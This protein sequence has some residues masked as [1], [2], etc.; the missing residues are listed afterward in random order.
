MNKDDISKV[1]S[2]IYYLKFFFKVG[3]LLNKGGIQM[4]K[5]ID[6]DEGLKGNEFYKIIVFNSETF[7]KIVNKRMTE[8]GIT[9]YDLAKRTGI[10]KY[11]IKR[12]FNGSQFPDE[13]DALKI[14]DAIG[15]K[16]EEFLA[17]LENNKNTD[18]SNLYKSYKEII[19]ILKI[20][21]PKDRKNLIDVIRLLGKQAI[22]RYMNQ[23]NEEK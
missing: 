4:K 10:D 15:F 18:W 17:E 8:L 12:Y 1:I 7:C 19:E 14:V 20:L 16:K 13:E 21:T 11:N 23:Y 3:C 22:E 5:D 2:I 6:S 9:L